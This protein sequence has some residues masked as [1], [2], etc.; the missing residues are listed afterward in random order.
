MKGKSFK[1]K[2]KYGKKKAVSQ[3]KYGAQRG[4]IRL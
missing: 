3:K 1:H 2:A 4:G